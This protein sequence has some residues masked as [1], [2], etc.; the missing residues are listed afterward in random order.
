MKSSEAPASV[1]DGAGIAAV[2]AATANAHTDIDSLDRYLV[3]GLRPTI[4]V[5]PDTVEELAAVLRAAASA[6]LAVVLQGG[7]TAIGLGTPPT[8][9]DVALDT[10][11]LNAVIDH[12]LDDFTITVQGGMRFAALQTF[13]AEH[14][15]FIPLDVPFPDRATVGG[16]VA[17]ARSGPRKGVFGGP[18]DWLIG[19]SVV[20]PHGVTVHGGGRVVKN[21]SG[22][23]LCKLFSGSWGTLG[24]IV[25]A[26]FKLRPLPAADA[27]L[28]IPT[29]DFAAAIELGRHVALK[30]NGLQSI[31]AFDT[32]SAHDLGL[33]EASLVLRAA[34][35]K[36]AVSSTLQLAGAVAQADSAIQPEPTTPDFWQRLTDREGTPPRGIAVL[37]RCA[38]PPDSLHGATAA[39][40]AATDQ[41]CLWAYADAGL[42]FGQ[43]SAPTSSLLP[44]IVATARKGIEALGGSLVVEHAPLTE[45][46]AMDVW[47]A[48]GD[49]IT[50]M[51]R[52]KREFDPNATLSPGRFVGGI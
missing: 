23:D 33:V 21:V 4:A 31:A 43:L 46:C 22:Y 49:G 8:R 3:D 2:A 37:V 19:C 38:A 9:Y 16:S 32:G 26:T 10:S 13:L 35:L 24:C 1:S 11:A 17:A 15:Q 5:R 25:E 27:T 34:G 52:I 50:I 30:V 14:G 47:G 45:K 41:T 42:L 39:L 44:A 18:R 6:G 12:V 40:R 28:V 29:G 7:R 48:A 36:G 51:R 20:L